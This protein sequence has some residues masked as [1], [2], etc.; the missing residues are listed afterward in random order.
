MGRSTLRGWNVVTESEPRLDSLGDVTQTM[1]QKHSKQNLVQYVHWKEFHP[2]IFH[3]KPSSQEHDCGITETSR[4]EVA[5]VWLLRGL[6]GAMYSPAEAILERRLSHIVEEAVERAAE[7]QASNAAWRRIGPTALAALPLFG[8][9]FALFLAHHDVHR[10]QLE[11]REQQNVQ[12]TLIPQPVTP[13][14][15]VV[16]T[17][18][19]IETVIATALFVAAGTIDFVDSVLHL[20]MSYNILTTVDPHTLQS[21]LH[22]LPERTTNHLAVM[23]EWSSSCVLSS[24]M[25]VGVGEVISFRSK[26]Q[27]ISV[28]DNAAMD[29]NGIPKRFSV[30]STVRI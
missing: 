23:E 22:T 29:R 15:T 21:T 27:D 7:R 5:T 24:A 12:F 25:C 17:S 4:G 13:N 1:I 6:A 20:L 2:L 18:R 28:Q 3:S 10:A 26:D 16:N 19:R 30:K 9:A 8:A 11:W 14:S